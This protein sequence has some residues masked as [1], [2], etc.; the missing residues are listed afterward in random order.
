MAINWFAILAEDNPMPGPGNTPQ[1]NAAAWGVPVDKVG[2]LGAQCDICAALL[3]KVKDLE[4][5]TSIVRAEC[6]EEFEKLRK[7][8]RSLHT[9]FCVDGF[10]VTA[11]RRLGLIPHGEGGVGHSKD[12]EDIAF[13]LRTHISNHE[14]FADFQRQ[15]ASSRDKGVHHAAEVRIW[16][17]RVDEPAPVSVKEAGWESYADTASPWHMAFDGTDAGMRLY[18]AMR[19]ENRSVSGGKDAGKGPWSEIKSVIIP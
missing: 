1:T 14:V 3:A 4:T 12:E 18:I 13:T 10:P 2:D 19:W 5:A 6:E 7:L 11:L 16:K 9:H 8:M 15:G 17:R